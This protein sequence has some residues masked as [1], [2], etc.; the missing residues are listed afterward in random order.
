V[1]LTGR[2]RESSK[3]GVFPKGSGVSGVSTDFIVTD[4]SKLPEGFA[5]GVWG[6]TTAW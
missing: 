5:D 2:G 6:G 3:F 1:Q 4:L